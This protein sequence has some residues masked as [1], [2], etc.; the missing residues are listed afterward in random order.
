MLYL[1]FYVVEANTHNQFTIS[2]IIYFKNN[3]AVLSMLQQ[4]KYNS[5]NKSK[6]KN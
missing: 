2:Q 1:F 3:N 6:E 4:T 5:S